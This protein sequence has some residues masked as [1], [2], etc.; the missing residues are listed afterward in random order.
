MNDLS[1]K[2]SVPIDRYASAAD[3]ARASLSPVKVCDLIFL[4]TS[5]DIDHIK[6]L[7]SAA[8]KRVLIRQRH[9]IAWVARRRMKCSF[10]EIARAMNKD[11]STIMHG[12]CVATRLRRRDK[13]FR[14]MC[15]R[16]E[17][18]AR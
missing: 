4:I 8:H 18:A 9:A 14:N 6:Q 5:G 1:H 11:H 3:L 12:Y 16:I 15:D 7:R 2:L 13:T 17:H 10:R